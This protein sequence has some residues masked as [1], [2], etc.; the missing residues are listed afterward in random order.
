MRN[1]RVVSA[2]VRDSEGIAV[3]ELMENVSGVGS[4]NENSELSR[5][6]Q[7]VVKETQQ[8]CLTYSILYIS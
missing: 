1:T 2:S 5:V 7:F 6:T 4:A 3:K 8:A